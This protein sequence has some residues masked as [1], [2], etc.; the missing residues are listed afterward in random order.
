MS[1]R[2]RIR[3]RFVSAAVLALAL[4]WVTV[5]AS[6]AQDCNIGTRLGATVLIPYFEYDPAGG[7]TTLFSVTNETNSPTMTR[8]VLWTDWGIPTL[9]FDVFLTPFDLQSFNV[10]DLFNGNIPSTGEGEDLSSFSFCNTVTFQPNHSNPAL[11]PAERTQIRNWHSGLGGGVLDD[12]CAGQLHADGHVRGFITIDTVDECSGI[13][14]GSLF[15]PA[16]GG[17]F[18]DGGGGAGAIGVAQNRLWGD[19]LIVDP[20]NA[21]AQG[22]EAISLWADAGRFTGDPTFTFYGRFS[23]YDGRD[24]RVPLPTLWATRFLNGGPFSGGTQLFVWRDVGVPASEP[25]T[26]GVPPSWYPLQEGFIVARDESG[27]VASRI[28]V[29]TESNFFPLATQRVPV[30]GFG[31]PYAFGRLQISLADGPNLS[32]PRQGWIQTVMSANGLYSLGLNAR[33]INELCDS[34][35]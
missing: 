18:V 26:C 33:G 6:Q 3:P 8:V 7:L 13:Q 5:P 25:L 17:Y 16:W 11:S 24:E 31:L 20:D 32:N 4:T 14:I 15:S 34:A 1:S 28:Q 23:G 12:R 27:D 29:G 35:P 21:F 9:G 10:R 22:S 2:D 30:T 19:F